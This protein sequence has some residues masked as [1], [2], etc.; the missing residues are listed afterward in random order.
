MPELS[1]VVPTCQRAELLERC[2]WS[3]ER[4]IHCDYEIIVVDGA[5]TDA[6]AAVLGRARQRLGDRLQIIREE[7]REGFTKAI[8][9]GFRAATG[10]YITW[11]NDDARPLPGTLDQAIEQMSQ[12]KADVGLVALFHAWNGTR[13]VAY[14]TRIGGGVYRLLHIR[15]T[16]YANFGLGRRETFAALGYFDERFF[17]YGADPDFSLKVW[18]AGMKVEPAYMTAIDHDEHEDARRHADANRGKED[19]DR[20]FA[21]WNLPVK[22][23]IRN[24]FDPAHPCTL[25]GRNDAAAMAI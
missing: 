17:I 15:G 16:L 3:V 19:N 1:I 18:N 25:L 8:N 22:N 2:L 11:L 7:R 12:S 6:T 5:S 24:D 9:K 23:L 21:K 13:S 10:R 20:L 14:E 4:G